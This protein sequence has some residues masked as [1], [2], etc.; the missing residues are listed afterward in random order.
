MRQ[1]ITTKYLGPTNFR[2]SRIKATAQAGS[3]TVSWDD[4]LDVVANHTKAAEALADKYGWTGR[5]HGGA[6]DTDGYVFVIECEQP[7]FKR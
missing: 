1:A 3:V 4:A 7:A 2:G 5:F 6:N